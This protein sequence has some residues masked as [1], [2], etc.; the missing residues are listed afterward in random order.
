MISISYNYCSNDIEFLDQALNE[1]VKVS[2]DIHITYVDHF[3]DGRIEDQSLLVETRKIIGNRAFLHELQFDPNYATQRQ[4]GE[5]GFRFWHNL[6]R[7]NNTIHSK[8][9]HVLYLDADE[10]LSGDDMRNWVASLDLSKV[11]SC[12]FLV[13]FYFRSKK[14]RA[15]T[16][17]LGPVLSNRNLLSQQDLMSDHERWTLVKP[18]YMR[19]VV[20][21]EGRPMIHHFS[22][23]KG[24]S[25]QECKAYLLRKVSS[26]S[27]AKDRDWTQL[28]EEEFSRS[29]NGKDFVHGYEYEV[30]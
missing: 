13:Y 14:F 3:F 2:N 30:I 22:W 21:L 28:I 15:K 6:C 7:I 8:H 11:S 27:H 16:W 24:S 23:A 5:L 25:D 17:E 12:V 1:A 29:F 10:V 20:S 19:D 18:P 9:S 4:G 26:W